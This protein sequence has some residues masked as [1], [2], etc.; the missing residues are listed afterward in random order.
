[1]STK[2]RLRVFIAVGI[3]AL[4]VLFIPL[5]VRDTDKEAVIARS[6][7]S[8]R[9]QDR[10][11]LDRKFRPFYDA[12]LIGRTARKWHYVNDTQ[13]SD[14]IFTDLGLEQLPD[15]YRDHVPGDWYE[16]GNVLVETTYRDSWGRSKK[17]HLRFNYYH[18][19]LGAQ[20]YRLHIYRCLL[21]TFVSYTLEWVS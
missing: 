4:V 12:A 20:G 5:P 9:N 16:S 19:S 8:L 15:Q 17:P 3:A 6:I 14:I 13:L 18:G 11:I 10:V 1:M 7:Q 21:G 2:R